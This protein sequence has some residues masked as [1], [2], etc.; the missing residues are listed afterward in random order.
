MF[1]KAWQV[2]EIRLAG[3]LRQERQPGTGRAGIVYFVNQVIVH[4]GRAPR[5]SVTEP[6]TV[7][8]D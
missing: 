4:D 5:E 2:T 6:D 3:A 8:R 1:P 7:E